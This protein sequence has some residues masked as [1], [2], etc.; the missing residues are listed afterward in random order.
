MQLCIGETVSNQ[1]TKIPQAPASTITAKS[2]HDVLRVHGRDHP[3]PTFFLDSHD[4]GGLD[5]MPI[6]K[7]AMRPLP[8]MPEDDANGTE[9]MNMDIH[10]K[11]SDLAVIPAQLGLAC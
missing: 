8:H 2:G 3:E 5:Q 4:V 10:Q 9:S 1:A 11:R 7:P 6:S